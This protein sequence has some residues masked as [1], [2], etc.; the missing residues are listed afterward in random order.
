M[1]ILEKGRKFN[2]GYYIAEIL[3]LL[4]QRRSIKAAGNKQKLFVHADM[5]VRI[6]PS[7]Q[8]NILTRIE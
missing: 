6:P 2:A 3:K 5:R 7:Y 4:S 1:K 8:L